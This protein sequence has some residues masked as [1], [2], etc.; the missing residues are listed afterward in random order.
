MYK[1]LCAKSGLYDGCGSTW[2]STDDCP[3]FYEYDLIDIIDFSFSFPDIKFPSVL[4]KRLY[5]KINLNSIT[6]FRRDKPFFY[7]STLSL[8][9]RN[10]L[11]IS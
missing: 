5:R 8:S 4:Y 10:S 3:L 7:L 2:M 1:S 11:K 9:V 6:S